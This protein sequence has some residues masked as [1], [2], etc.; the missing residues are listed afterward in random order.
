MVQKEK[1][2]FYVFSL[3]KACYLISSDTIILGESG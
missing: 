3:T 1:V 2:T